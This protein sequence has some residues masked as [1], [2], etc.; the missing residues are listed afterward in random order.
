MK[1]ILDA[2]LILLGLIIIGYAI[3]V[4]AP[5]FDPVTENDKPQL[6]P[7][8]EIEIKI[9]FV[10]DMML[11]RYIRKQARSWGYDHFFECIKPHLLTR[12]FV[13]G[14][15]E[16]T[17]T[18]YESVSEGKTEEDMNHFRFTFDPTSLLA[19]K[20][21]GINILGV[22][23]NH[24]FDFGREGVK[25]TRENILAKEINYFGDPL[26]ENYR[27]LKIEKEDIQ[28]YFVPFNQ[29]FGSSAETTSDIKKIR[30]NFENENEGAEQESVAG[31]NNL[32]QKSKQPLI[33]VY[34]HWGDEY[35]PANQKQKNWAREFIDAGADM[36]IGMHPHVLQETEIYKDKFIAYSLGNFVFDQYFN[37]DVKR[38]GIVDVLIRNSKIA[39]FE[40]KKTFLNEKRQVCLIE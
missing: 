12:D 40:L 11:D 36:I 16:G 38:G 3:F 26:D 5:V 13:V 39:N 6:F 17:I 23:N 30:A 34:A 20:N 22:S 25:M 24:I 15:L 9:T 31:R 29:F 32:R 37:E 4:Y 1:K 7:K 35:V 27:I 18:N 19:I 28:I 21:S 33:F 2:V 14:N 8:E 10:G